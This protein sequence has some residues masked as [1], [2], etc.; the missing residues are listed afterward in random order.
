MGACYHRSPLIAGQLTPLFSGK[1][2]KMKQQQQQ[3]QMKILV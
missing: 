3:Q 1:K 2:K